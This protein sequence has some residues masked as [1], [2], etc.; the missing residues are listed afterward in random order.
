MF[1]KGRS[2]YPKIFM[3]HKIEVRESSIHG[4]GVFTRERLDTND[5]IEAAPVILFHKD[6][7]DDF[8]Y[9]RKRE[10]R[11]NP[12]GGLRIEG[13]HDRHVL[14][15]Y[16]FTWKDKML[17]FGL[18]YAGIYNH[19]TEEPNAIWRP[20][21]EYECIEIFALHNIE[22]GEE[23]TVRYV[24]Y[25]NCDTL[26]FVSDEPNRMLDKPLEVEP[27]DTPSILDLHKKRS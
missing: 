8:D 17:A 25:Q 3:S 9:N 5:L 6:T 11:I 18:G 24:K 27:E 26:W 10:V 21:F 2:S 22:P 1:K 23:I 16:P 13:V 14:M 20:N 7:C 15:D 4:W 12:A 19:S